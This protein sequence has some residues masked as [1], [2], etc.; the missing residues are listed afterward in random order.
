[1][2]MGAGGRARKR[3][4]GKSRPRAESRTR[5]DADPS[6][7]PKPEPVG[8][9]IN[10]SSS[11]DWETVTTSMTTFLGV[12]QVARGA[13]GDVLVAGGTYVGSSPPSISSLIRCRVG[14]KDFDLP[15]LV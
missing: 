13:V 6:S 3:P 11:S 12:F 14:S 8:D 9:P 4:G 7:D 15:R 5:A 2:C 1:M 10:V